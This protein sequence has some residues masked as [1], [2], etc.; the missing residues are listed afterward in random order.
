LSNPYEPPKAPLETSQTRPGFGWRVVPS[1]FMVLLGAYTVLGPLIMIVVDVVRSW[2]ITGG[3]GFVR[4]LG[5]LIM[6]TAGSLWIVSGAM[7]W[8]RRW[9]IA[10]VLLLVGYAVGLFAC[11]L[12]WGTWLR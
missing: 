6:S 5:L 11:M 12:L 3:L 9:W 1:S 4:T 7:F 2:G 8:K 10:V